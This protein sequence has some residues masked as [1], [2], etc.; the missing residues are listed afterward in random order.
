MTVPTRAVVRVQAGE[1]VDLGDFEHVIRGAVSG[2]AATLAAVVAQACVLDGFDA[3]YVD[4]LTLRVTRNGGAFIAPF[5]APANNLYS[6][7]ALVASLLNDGD[8]AV[9]VDLGL[10]ALVHD[11]YHVYVVTHIVNANN[12]ERI[13]L[14]PTTSL[15]YPNNIDTRWALTWSLTTALTTA[16]A[17]ANGARVAT[18]NWDGTLTPAKLYQSKALLFEGAAVAGASPVTVPAPVNFDHTHLPDFDRTEARA[19]VGSTTIAEFCRAV[20]KRIEEIGDPVNGGWWR[21]PPYALSLQSVRSHTLSIGHPG[22]PGNFT[23]T[24]TGGSLGGWD[25]STALTSAVAAAA[26]IGPCSIVLHAGTYYLNGVRTFTTAVRFS[27][28]GPEL[29]TLQ[30]GTSGRLDFNGAVDSVL[31]NIALVATTGTAAVVR[32]TQQTSLALS[33]VSYR[34][35][36]AVVAQPAC[37]EVA[38]AG[39]ATGG[40]ALADCD[41]DGEVMALLSVAQIV[42]TSS[43][44]QSLRAQDPGTVVLVQATVQN[45][46]VDGATGTV[47]VV[48]SQMGRVSLTGAAAGDVDFLDTRFSGA[49]TAAAVAQA[50]R[51]AVNLTGAAVATAARLRVARCNFESGDV[52]KPLNGL[53]L[54]DSLATFAEAQIENLDFRSGHTSETLG[55]GTGY[56]LNATSVATRHALADVAVHDFSDNGVYWPGVGRDVT[57]RKDRRGSFGGGTMVWGLTQLDGL[58]LVVAYDPALPPTAVPAFS[59]RDVLVLRSAVID[60]PDCRTAYQIAWPGSASSDVAV[61]SDIDLGNPTYGATGIYVSADS[62]QGWRLTRGRFRTPDAITYTRHDGDDLEHLALQNVRFDGDY[63]AR[64]VSAQDQTVRGAAC[65]WSHVL[66]GGES[67][68]FGQWRAV[69]ISD[70]SEFGEGLVVQRAAKN[71]LGDACI[72][73]DSTFFRA[74]MDGMTPGPNFAN[75]TNSWQTCL[76]VFGHAGDDAHDFTDVVVERCR[77]RGVLTAGLYASP[78]FQAAV[79]VDAASRAVIRD[80]EAYFEATA[81]TGSYSPFLLQAREMRF[82]RNRVRVVGSAAGWDVAEVVRLISSGA[83]TGEVLTQ[84]GEFFVVDSCTFDLAYQSAGVNEARLEESLVRVGT[85]IALGTPTRL[86]SFV[87]NRLNF[88]AKD[89]AVLMVAEAVGLE[90]PA[91]SR[92]YGLANGNLIYERRMGTYPTVVAATLVVT[93]ADLTT[94]S[95][96]VGTNVIVSAT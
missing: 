67:R 32:T 49:T 90:F 77:F 33:N 2:D 17:P 5:L 4:A 1:R 89:A 44:I 29:V 66:V 93:R 3:A 64:T 43:S 82:E 63:T 37:L 30:F 51:C 62:L 74:G 86:I 6:S 95:W 38:A 54:Y 55:F 14:N 52:T 25:I 26:A 8:G 24:T 42:T 39:A 72:I 91:G 18:V 13:F 45:M 79:R 48:S 92:D 31:E 58:R 87:D 35:V 9:A 11:W 71:L 12:E 76:G 61:W 88:P 22:L 16:A 21:T 80:C 60:V 50:P 10:G 70:G 23:A 56:A 36:T 20:L 83:A 7:G 85:A 27:G 96:A 47:A 73:R 81:D 78:L 57:V 28:L 75:L 15:E 69:E 19:T 46:S 65:R 94:V 53:Y 68:I 41:I 84:Q 59:V 40:L 34:Y